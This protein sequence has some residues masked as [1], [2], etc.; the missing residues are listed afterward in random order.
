MLDLSDHASSTVLTSMISLTP[1][2]KAYAAVEKARR[3]SITI[4]TPFA[5]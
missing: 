4:A 2:E 3:T 5:V 1:R